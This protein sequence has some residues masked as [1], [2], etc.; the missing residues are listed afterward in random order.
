D[1]YKSFCEELMKSGRQKGA[2]EKFLERAYIGVV[3]IGALFAIEF[4]FSGFIFELFLHK[5]FN[6]PISAGFLIST[7]LI[8]VSALLIYW[9][10][11]KYS[12]E[13][14]GKGITKYKVLFVIGFTAFF[15]GTILTNVFF[16]NNDL[17]KINVFI[18]ISFLAAAYLSVKL[19]GDRNANQIAETRK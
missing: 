18:P 12:F 19:L 14:S 9:F 7:S 11:T 15:S 2:Y 5:D 16:G 13:L 3:G 1:D 4:V 8:I 10:F 17:F 6:M